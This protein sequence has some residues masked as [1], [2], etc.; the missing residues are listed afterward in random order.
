MYNREVNYYYV[1]HSILHYHIEETTAVV[2]TRCKQLHLSYENHRFDQSE[3]FLE[4]LRVEN[5]I[6]RNTR[7]KRNK[8]TV[9]AEN[10]LNVL[11]LIFEK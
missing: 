1:K 9:T 7:V 2:P 4:N 5:L 10:I 8:N 11:F 3:F 6:F